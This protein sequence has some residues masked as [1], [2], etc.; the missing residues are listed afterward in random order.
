MNIKLTEEEK[1]TLLS[2]YRFTY[3]D[4]KKVCR[5][6]DYSKT[7]KEKVYKHNLLNLQNIIKKFKIRANFKPL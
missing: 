5:S 2:I 3:T 1:E 7:F 4:Y 6:K